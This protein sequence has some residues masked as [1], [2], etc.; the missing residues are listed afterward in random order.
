MLKNKAKARRDRKTAARSPD[1]MQ[2]RMP[3][4]RRDPARSQPRQGQSPRKSNIKDDVN[5]LAFLVAGPH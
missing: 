5:P 3:I 2:R 1:I 4:I